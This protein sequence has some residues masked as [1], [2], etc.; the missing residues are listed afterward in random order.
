[1][2]SLNVFEAKKGEVRGAGASRQ[3]SDRCSYLVAPPPL[4]KVVTAPPPTPLRSCWPQSVGRNGCDLSA[5]L[6]SP[7]FF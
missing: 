4:P 3:T 1:M 7:L 2:D 5:C 6:F